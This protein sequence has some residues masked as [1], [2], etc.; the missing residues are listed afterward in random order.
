[1]Y[2]LRFQGVEHLTGASGNEDRFVF[3]VGASLDGEIDGGAGGFDTLVL[4]GGDSQRAIFTAYGPDA[5]LIETDLV[6]L[7][8]RGLEPID[9]IGSTDAVINLTANDDIAVL[10]NELGTLRLRSANST[11]ELINFTDGLNSLTINGVG[12]NDSI[13]VTD[14]VNISLSGVFHLE[15]ESVAITSGAVISAGSVKLVA[16]DEDGPSGV[17]TSVAVED[18]AASIIVAG[19]VTASS[20]ISLEATATRNV[21]VSEVLP[22]GGIIA[23]TIASVQV[24][25][26]ATLTSGGNTTITALTDGVVELTAAGAALNLIEESAT[27][28]LGGGAFLV[29][30]LAATATTSTNYSAKARAAAN[31]VSGQ[32]RD[33][34]SVV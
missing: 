14:G 17:L 19:T 11:F 29:G 6:S 27:V 30:G 4:H 20:T 33:R 8:Y 1:M 25:N 10:E 23:S 18:L 21:H 15:A 26:S 7:V 2:G 16:R 32:V 9:Y 3:E 22:I 5:G 28:D 12:G 13:T 24:A 31:Q 34:K